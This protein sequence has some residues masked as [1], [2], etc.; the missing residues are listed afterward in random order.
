[1]F[2]YNNSPKRA[3]HQINGF[4]IWKRRLKN[5]KAKVKLYTDRQ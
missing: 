3:F 2:L 1:M 5:I 4:L